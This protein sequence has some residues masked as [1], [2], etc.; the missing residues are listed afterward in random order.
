[1]IV[2]EKGLLKV[3]KEAHKG[4]GYS[5]AVTNDASGVAGECSFSLPWHSPHCWR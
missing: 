2:N 5:V 4:Y 1:M 3:M